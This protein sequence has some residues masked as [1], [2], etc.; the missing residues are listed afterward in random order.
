MGYAGAMPN[1]NIPSDPAEL[2]ESPITAALLRKQ[3]A[4]WP[5]AAAVT[6]ELLRSIDLDDPAHGLIQE[7]LAYGLLQG[8]NEHAAWLSRR[9]HATGSEP[10]QVQVSRAGD[11]L[12][13]ILDRPMA[14]NAIDRAMR[15]A[16]HEAFTVATLDPDVL[17]VRLLGAGRAFCVG[18][19]L[20]EFGTT[21]DPAT[22]HCIRMQTLP[23]LAI[24]RCGHKF[25]AHVQGACVGSGLEMVAFAHRVT[26]TPDAWFQLPELAMGLIPGAGGCVSVAR[27]IGRRRAA[28]LILSGK[29]INAKTALDWGLIDAIV[30]DLAVDHRQAD[31]VG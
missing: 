6:L 10:G 3:V 9:R 14:S 19:D 29:R 25:E 16:L 20:D 1:S 27:R 28:L 22:A 30:D 8:G 7:S 15:D 18:A 17:I 5:Q 2:A 11:V 26:A 12:Q 31:M 21:R 4:A 23:A 24:I 13:I